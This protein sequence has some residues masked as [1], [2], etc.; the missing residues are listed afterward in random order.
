LARYALSGEEYD[1]W[2]RAVAAHGEAGLKVTALQRLRD[3]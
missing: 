3:R 1:E 2:A